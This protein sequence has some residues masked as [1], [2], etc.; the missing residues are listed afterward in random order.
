MH[1]KNTSGA[2]PEQELTTAGSAYATTGRVAYHWPL[3][4]LGAA[5]YFQ[6]YVAHKL[7]PLKIVSFVCRQI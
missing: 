1:L 2:V 6:T 4:N 3:S 7:S 5:E